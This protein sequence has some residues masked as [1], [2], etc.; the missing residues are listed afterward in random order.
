MRRSIDGRVQGR[1]GEAKQDRRDHKSTSEEATQVA[2]LPKGWGVR[3]GRRRCWQRAAPTPTPPEPDIVVKIDRGVRNTCGATPQHMW[4]SKTTHQ[5]HAPVGVYPSLPFH[6]AIQIST[7]SSPEPQCELCALTSRLPTKTQYIGSLSRARQTPKSQSAR[8]LKNLHGTARA[9]RRSVDGRRPC[10]KWRRQARSQRPQ[11]GFRRWPHRLCAAE[12]RLRIR[13]TVPRCRRSP[14][15]V[16]RC[17]PAIDARAVIQVGSTAPTAA[18]KRHTPHATR[19]VWTCASKAKTQIPT[20]GR[21]D[22]RIRDNGCVSASR[23]NSLASPTREAVC[24]LWLP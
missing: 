22:M 16:L 8:V 13:M 18:A 11:A 2:A 5:M 14:E 10:P 6:L 17:W 19:G 24:L 4:V 20:P 12:K 23:S 7:I 15:Y 9:V 1:N 3:G 21:I